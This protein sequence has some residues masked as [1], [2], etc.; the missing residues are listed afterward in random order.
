MFRHFLLWVLL[1]MIHFSVRAQ[2]TISGIVTD[3]DN[4]KLDFASVFLEKTQYATSTVEQGTFK[5]TNVEE[6]A[7]ILK[8]VFLG[9]E[10][11]EANLYVG[12]DQY[13]EIVLEGSAFQLDE[14]EIRGTWAREKYPF[15][16]TNLDE[17]EI[18][19]KNTVTDVPFL[20]QYEPSVVVSSDAGAGVGY[21][22]IRIRGVD[23][24]R[25]NVT[26]NGIPLNDAESQSVY[27]VNL[28][29]VMNS[30][31]EVQIQRGVGTSTN[32]AGA[33]GATINLNTNKF[34][35]KPYAGVEGAI[36][37][38]GT[39]KLA[40]ELGTGLLNEKFS[41]EGRYSLVSSDG[42][43]D[44]ARSA[45]NSFYV[46]AA[47]VSKQQSLRLNIFSG[48][49]ITYQS[50]Y[51]LPIQYLDTNR[52]FNSAGTDYDFMVE[53]PY[54]NEI[55]N[56]RQTHY[57]L[58]WNKSLSNTTNVE[59]AGHYT[60]GLGF[61]EQF[62]S[63]ETL[64]DYGINPEDETAD[65]V[66][67]KWLDNH[68]FGMVFNLDK[69][70][71]KSNLLL[72]GGIH[73]YIGRHFGEVDT[74]Y[75]SDVFIPDNL[76]Y[77]DNDA[78]KLDMNVYA[79][80]QHNFGR[81]S[82]F[83][84]LQ[85]R[86]IHYRFLGLSDEREPLDQTVTLHFFN[87]KAGANYSF[88]PKSRIYASFSVANREPNREDY[89][90]SPQS[91]LPQPER[92]YNTEI[93]YRFEGNRFNGGMNLYY[94]DYKDQLVLTGKINEVGDYTKI[95]IPDSYR[96]GIELDMNLN[97]LSV[98]QLGGAITLSQNKILS[99]TEYVDDWDTFDQIAIEHENTDISFSPPVIASA[100]L[101]WNILGTFSELEDHGL[102]LVL[103]NKY[104]G[105]Q[106]M[107]N[108]QNETARLDA[109]NY[110]D[111]RVQYSFTQKWLK[112]ATLEL[113]VSN[114]LNSHYVSNGWVYRFKSANYNPVPFDP[115]ATSD[116]PNNYYYQ[117]GLFPQATRH[118]TLKLKVDF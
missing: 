12:K 18:Q 20:L 107:D 111:A 73:D 56:Y 68:F 37:S 100:D 43:V 71:E 28:P 38:F 65:L 108:T 90:S 85:Y 94:M 74:V 33:F 106:Y 63:A 31:D 24:T 116:Q 8:V 92:L 102:N 78:N 44:R 60:R 26:V 70:F 89:V 3:T 21:T 82:L 77:Y 53:T 2:Y 113:F 76:L 15:A 79:K 48:H 39:K 95:N 22:G 97:V 51:G 54:D 7:Y 69:S 41:L 118:Y 58:F 57:Q 81:L 115:Y 83:G 45:L 114:L 5:I 105:R 25:I 50:W 16:F 32:G 72:G 86:L 93:G 10:P 4:N 110:L 42:Y 27:W 101:R 36:G 34:R 29:D 103:T 84:D 67:R 14:V 19:E 1:V 109:F 64:R 112:N 62:K 59:L 87:P 117:V 98:L 13:V 47:R 91:S 17:K 55:D 40:V 66:R 9:Y 30:V 35:I 99:F 52:T 46:T 75:S 80:Y 6:G 11:Y 49:E 96:A 104:V 23:P 61:F 88:G